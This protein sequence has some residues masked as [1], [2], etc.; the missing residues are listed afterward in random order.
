MLV[1]QVIFTMLLGLSIIAFAEKP[2]PQVAQDGFPTGQTSPE[3]AASDLARAFIKQ[4]VHWFR[5]LCVRPY[6]AGQ[7]RTEYVAYLAD[8]SSHFRHDKPQQDYPSKISRVFAARHLS[9]NGPA[10]FGYAGFNFQDVMFVDVEVASRS[11]GT[12]VRRTMVIK[13]RDGKWY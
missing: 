1:R 2:K 7:S 13:D 9:K 6:G 8:V 12:H 10:S 3:G 4:D 11:G 5:S